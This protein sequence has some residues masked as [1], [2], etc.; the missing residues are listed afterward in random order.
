MTIPA[1]YHDLVG[2][3]H[4]AH[5]ATMNADGS[6]QSTV[7]WIQRDGDDVLFT[8]DARYRK[9]RN[10]VRNSRVALS[11]HDA[12][13][14][15]RYLELR[16]TVEIESR[17]SYDFLD[18]LAKQYMD[19]EAYPYKRP[20]AEGI[21]VRICVLHAVTHHTR[22]TPPSLPLPEGQSDLLGAPHFGHIATATPAGQ[23]CSSPVWITREADDV[24]FW[25]RATS[26]KIQNL[27]HNPTIAVSVHDEAN[28]MRYIE[29]RGVAELTPV[30]HADLLD[31]LAP[32]YWQV[33][34]YPDKVPGLSG[35]EVRVKVRHT[36][37]FDG[38]AWTQRRD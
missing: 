19:V 3:P 7:V 21:H 4:F 34:Q 25:T 10:M 22:D 1:E 27:Q 5:L 8:T 36:S 33:A 2:A 20:D 15:Y 12:A 23:P 13:D 35:V 32:R 37:G 6:P 16:G 31:E 38:R 14:P 28:P 9:A 29:V 24:L 11:I 26:K 17:Q 18:G 30:P